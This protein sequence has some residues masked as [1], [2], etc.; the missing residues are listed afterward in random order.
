[1]E[2][3]LWAERYRP[4]TLDEF[5]GNA[6]IK[7][8]VQSYI[9]QKDIPHLLFFGKAGTG[10]TSLAKLI[11]AHIESDSLYINAS[12]ENN[13]ETVRTKIKSFASTISFSP[14][15]FI[16]LDEADYLTINGQ[17]ALR[18]IM[19]EFHKNCRFILTCNYIE[20]IIEP[21]RSRVQDFHIFPP[22]KKDIAIHIAKILRNEKVEFVPADVLN[23]VNIHYPDIRKIIGTSQLM[24]LNGKLNIQKQLLIESDFH[25]KLLDILKTEKN[26][27]KMFTD[28]RQLVANSQIRSFIDTYRLLFD[29]ID[30]F[31]KDAANTII[32]LAESQYQDALVIDKEINFAACIAKLVDVIK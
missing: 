3:T 18:V 10:K 24:S 4:E 9:T 23:I 31:T 30:E 8:K 32:I 12:D 11:V 27:A 22:S 26:K 15:K 7:E 14:N 5:I 21:I 6:D 13:I 28:I 17:A 2:S 29:T 1:M 25:A 20:R 16:I 19:E